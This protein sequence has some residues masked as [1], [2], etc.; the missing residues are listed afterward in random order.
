[1]YY[2]QAAC[3]TAFFVDPKQ[4]LIIIMMMQVRFGPQLEVYRRAVQS[5]AYQ[6]LTAPN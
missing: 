3:G 5:L 6:A 2:W 4:K 1:M